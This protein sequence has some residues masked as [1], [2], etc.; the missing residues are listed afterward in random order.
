MRISVII[1]VYNE[2]FTVERQ[3]AQVAAVLPEV[4][5]E[6]I[7]VDDGSTEDVASVAR[8]LLS[9]ESRWI[10]GQTLAVDGGHCL[11]RGP[12]YRSLVELIF[13]ADPGAVGRQVRIDG[14]VQANSGPMGRAIS[15]GVTSAPKVRLK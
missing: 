6:I 2:F 13:G 11:R 7:V 5:K 12:D 4:A 3:L 15:A 1:P 8:F 9:D 10:T 14:R